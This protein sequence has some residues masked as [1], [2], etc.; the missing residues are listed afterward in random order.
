MHPQEIM[1]QQAS[2]SPE[3]RELSNRR[4]EVLHKLNREGTKRSTSLAELIAQG[5]I[6]LIPH[7]N[8]GSFETQHKFYGIFHS[9]NGKPK[10]FAVFIDDLDVDGIYDVLTNDIYPHVQ[11][12][13]L[14][15]WTIWTHPS[16]GRVVAVEHRYEIGGFILGPFWLIAKKAPIGLIILSVALALS[17]AVLFGFNYFTSI[18]AGFFWIAHSKAHAGIK[19]QELKSSGYHRRADVIS[20]SK[21]EAEIA[22]AEQ[23]RL[24]T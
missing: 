23:N 2:M 20:Y 14:R 4:V 9:D 10:I 18:W 6:L 12:M 21:A 13:K 19:A 17:P 15:A 16:T 7:S 22:F 11:N 5:R 24:G 1:T 3:D 8:R